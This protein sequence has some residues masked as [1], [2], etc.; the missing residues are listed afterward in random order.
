M[1]APEQVATGHGALCFIQA[2][3]PILTTDELH[4]PK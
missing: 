4:E 2:L 1:L 3:I